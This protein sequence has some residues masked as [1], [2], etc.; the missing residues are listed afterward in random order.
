[1]SGAPFP[2]LSVEQ[3]IDANLDRAREGLRVIEDWCRF[4]ISRKDFVI[5]IK[6]WRQRLGMCHKKKYKQARFTK[7]D[8]GLGLKHPSQLER[9]EPW[10]IITANCARVQ[11]ALRVIEE[12][13]RNSDHRLAETASIIRYGLYEIEKEILN[14][15]IRTNRLRKLSESKLC[16]ITEPQSNLNEKVTSALEAGVKM[17]QYRHK[18]ATHRERFNE[19][20][21]IAELCRKFKAL[22][23]VNDHIDIA[24][25]VD[26]DGVHLGQTDMPIAI[27]RKLLGSEKLIGKSTHSLQD[28]YKAESEGPD[29]M[30]FGPIFSTKTKANL[31]PLGLQLLQEASRMARLPFFAIGGINNANLQ[32]V[33]NQGAKR[34]AVISAIMRTENPVLTTQKLLSSLK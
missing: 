9:I 6:D 4:G 26:A 21:E 17:V 31:E 10:E 16:L 20:K 32:E 29:Y 34:V 18:E 2:N 1:M 33:L 27:A 12:F 28:I 11:E 22:F 25:A 19:A 15:D 3:L 24:L 13:S 5:T 30:G 7:K 14:T 8:A 23:I